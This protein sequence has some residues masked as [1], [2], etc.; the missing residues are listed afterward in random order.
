MG[1]G[2]LFVHLK[3][4]LV[5]RVGLLEVTLAVLDFA[6]KG[7]CF[8]RPRRTREAR[9]GLLNLV[10]KKKVGQCLG[11]GRLPGCSLD[12]PDKK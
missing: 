3:G 10:L 8:S 6:L 2:R 9:F 1:S 12:T 11:A 5:K 4:G 7:D